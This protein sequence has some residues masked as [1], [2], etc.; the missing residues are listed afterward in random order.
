MTNFTT[1]KKKKKEPLKKKILYIQ[2]MSLCL[3]VFP[4]LLPLV[5]APVETKDYYLEN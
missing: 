3:S 4:S 1:N 2:N 5:S